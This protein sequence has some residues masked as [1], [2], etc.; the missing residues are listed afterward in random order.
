MKLVQ[1]RRANKCYENHFYLYSYQCWFKIHSKITTAAAAIIKKK[2]FWKQ[3]QSHSLASYDILS[4]LT[5]NHVEK[6][7]ENGKLLPFTIQ[8]GCP[9][10]RAKKKSNKD[11]VINMMYD[12]D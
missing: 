7:A 1:F 5:E 4:S 8:F 3:L 2:H 12:Y 10:S 11:S 9:D 6:G